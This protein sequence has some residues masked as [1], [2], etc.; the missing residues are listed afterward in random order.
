[1]Q[2]CKANESAIRRLAF[3]S[4]VE[5]SRAD[6]VPAVCWL[7]I[8][9]SLLTYSTKGRDGG[10][11]VGLK[12]VAAGPTLSTPSGMR[13][14]RQRTLSHLAGAGFRLLLYQLPLSWP[15]CFVRSVCPFCLPS[16]QSSLKSRSQ[17][18]AQFYKKLI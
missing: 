14:Q 15:F 12:S 17:F 1:M 16:V 5:L 18:A 8:I 13:P 4:R 9:I 2:R 6:S 10:V 7:I 11:T 3:Y